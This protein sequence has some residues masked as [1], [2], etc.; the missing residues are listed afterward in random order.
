MW[1]FDL[2]AGLIFGMGGIIL[3]L[4]G[5]EGIFFMVLLAFIWVLWDKGVLGWVVEDWREDE[6]VGE[7]VLGELERDEVGLEEEGVWG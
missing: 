6:G 3:E 1:E 7:M 2:E 5:W 4:R